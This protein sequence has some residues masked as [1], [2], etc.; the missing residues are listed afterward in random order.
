[1][2]RASHR[3]GHLGCGLRTRAPP[4]GADARRDR[5]R[6]FS[7]VV[8]R[9]RQDS[10]LDLCYCARFC[11]LPGRAKHHAGHP[12]DDCPEVADVPH[13]DRRGGFFRRG[14]R[15]C[16]RSPEGV[17]GHDGGLGRLARRG[18][19]H[20]ADGR[21]FRRRHQAGRR[22]AISARRL[23]R[24]RGVGC[25]ARIFGLGGRGARRNRLVPARGGRAAPGDAGFGR[26][27]R[28]RGREIPDS[29]WP[30][31]AAAPH[32]RPPFDDPYAGDHAAAV[33]SG[34]LIRAGR[35]VHRPPVHAR[36]RALRGQA[37]AQDLRLDLH[38]DR[39]VRRL[40]ASLF[41]RR[42]ERIR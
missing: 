22:H 36:D 10:L 33:A 39:H 24:T 4:R 32:R 7:L 37:I 14:P 29:G 40:S 26:R 35:L 9:A 13:S 23:R 31:A 42:R 27:R 34:D 8:R 11:R 3:V 38:P 12:D 21:S 17:S 2:G 41:T 6:D 25:R 5:G 15:L 1:M 19:R 20:G 18:D 16:P 28:G 30:A